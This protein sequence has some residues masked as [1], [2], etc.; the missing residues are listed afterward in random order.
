MDNYLIVAMLVFFAGIFGAR[1][2]NEAA[3]NILNQEQKALLIDALSGIRKK[4]LIAVVVIVIIFL[5]LS[6]NSNFPKNQLFFIYFGLLIALM[7]TTTI[8]TRKTLI[9][10]QFPKAYI[11]QY[12]LSSLVR[13][14]GIG[15]F[16]IVM[17]MNKEFSF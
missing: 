1:F 6:F 10:N 13:Y 8:I 2:I 15:V 11:N 12:I 3:F 9:E 5:F 16:L 4:T 7:T 17:F 14:F